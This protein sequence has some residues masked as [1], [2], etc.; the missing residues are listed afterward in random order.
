[1]GIKRFGDYD[2]TKGYGTFQALP[3]GGY[4]MRIQGATVH[5]NSNGQYVKIAADIAE[6]E[7]Q[8]YY[9]RDYEG[10]QTEDKKWHCNYL[11]SVPNDDGS[12][13]DGWTKRRFKTFTEALEE[14]NPGYHFDW[15][16]SKFKGLIIGGL[17]NERE[18]EK[19][20]GSIGRATNFAQVCSVDAVRAG[21]FKLPDDKLLGRSG[22]GNSGGDSDDG[23]MNI[24]D[25]V[26]D[27]LPFD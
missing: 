26:A 12:E 11:L 23:F 27:E 19:R 24:P 13:Q 10:Q 1:M 5:E 8:G 15:D 21:R 2:K 9:A 18:Y 22:A 6:G 4:V 16:E 17:F 25:G 20:D 3:K 7:Y 14:S